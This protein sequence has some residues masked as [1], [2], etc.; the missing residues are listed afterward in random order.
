MIDRMA[1]RDKLRGKLR[2]AVAALTAAV[3]AIATW[4]PPQVQ[5]TPPEQAKCCFEVMTYNMYL[6]AN[7][8][9][10]FQAKDLDELRQLATEAYAHVHQVDFNLRAVA[11]AAQIVQAEPEVVGLQELS[12]WQEVLLSNPSELTTRY[13]FLQ[14]LLDELE[15][16]GHPYV[17]AS[18][19]ETFSSD[20]VPI[21]DPEVA[22]VKWTDRNAVIAR[23]DLSASELTTA[24]PMGAKFV[25]YLPVTIL[26]TP[27]RAT[28]AWT[29]VDVRVMGAWFRVFDT[30]FEA[31][32][33]LVRLAQVGELVAIMS[34]SPYPIVL[35]GDINLYPQSADRPEDRQAWN[36]L[37][38]AGFV[39][40]WVESDGAFPAYTAGQPD[41]L[42]CTLPSTLDNT[43]DF[44]LHDADGYVDAVRHSGDIVGEDPADCTKTTPPLWPS[45]HAGV[46]VGLHIPE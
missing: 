6:G 7:I 18:V 5:A 10:L 23:A 15:A 29:S 43:V 2:I 1:V 45:D 25:T 41:D 14:I 12:L 11:I 31:F 19:V 40:A 17:A 32:H 44:V 3:V 24:N 36:I 26:G 27:I 4:S 20:P 42:D 21:N 22:A 46:V 35:A 39:D 37:T 30:H 16:Q 8:Q 38:G 28:R 33:P 9:P 13:D 34:A